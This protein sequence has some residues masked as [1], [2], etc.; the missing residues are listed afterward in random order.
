MAY[1]LEGCTCLSNLDI[2][3]VATGPNNHASVLVLGGRSCSLEEVLRL[4]EH[5]I[6]IVA[7]INL[8]CT[9]LGAEIEVQTLALVGFHSARQDLTM[10]F[11]K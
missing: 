8:E 6:D 2:E 3:V 1:S 4:L 5:N 9:A 11:S 7:K 10:E